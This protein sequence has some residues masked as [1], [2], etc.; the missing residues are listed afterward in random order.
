MNDQTCHQC[1]E[2]VKL[3]DETVHYCAKPMQTPSLESTIQQCKEFGFN[4]QITNETLWNT[5][6]LLGRSRW[7]WGPRWFVLLQ[8][9]INTKLGGK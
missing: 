5:A 3:D 7:Y 2:D 6:Y 1:G 9:W 8:G 4:E